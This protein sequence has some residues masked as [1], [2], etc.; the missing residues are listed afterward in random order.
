LNVILHSVLPPSIVLAVEV[1]WTNYG[2]SFMPAFVEYSSSDLLKRLIF[3]R[4]NQ[5]RYHLLTVRV[6][7]TRGG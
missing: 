7:D 6:Q 5:L 4:E 1:R 2:L 3:E